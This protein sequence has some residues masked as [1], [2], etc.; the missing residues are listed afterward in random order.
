MSNQRLN[1]DLARQ[2]LHEILETGRSEISSSALPETVTV[3][4]WRK[5]AR[6]VGECLGCPIVTVNHNGQLRACAPEQATVA[7]E[8]LAR[9]YVSTDLPAATR[10]TA[11]SH[12]LR[13]TRAAASS[14]YR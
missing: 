4:R 9:D 7:A 3:E 2:I 11:P 10:T 13:H 12:T 8:Y 14:L 1:A 6:T 5:I